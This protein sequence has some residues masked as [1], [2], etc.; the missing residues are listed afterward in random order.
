MKAELRIIITI[1][2]KLK[3]IISLVDSLLIYYLVSRLKIP[4]ATFRL[5]RQGIQCFSFDLMHVAF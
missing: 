3:R 4:S 2:T 1:N 5:P